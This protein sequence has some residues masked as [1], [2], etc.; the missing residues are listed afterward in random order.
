MIKSTRLPWMVGHATPLVGRGLAAAAGR[1]ARAGAGAAARCSMIQSFE[2][3]CF[4]LQVVFLTLNCICSSK[5][6]ISSPTANDN[7]ITR[8]HDCNLTLIHLLDQD[9]L[10]LGRGVIEW[11]VSEIFV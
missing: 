11:D 1:A 7:D 3:R 9:S 10:Y 6:S 4:L 5:S 2:S 8:N